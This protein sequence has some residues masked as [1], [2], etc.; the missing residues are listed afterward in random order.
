MDIIQLC[1]EIEIQPEIKEKVIQ[2]ANHFDFHTVDKYLKDFFVYEKMNEACIELCSIL[3]DDDQHIKILVCMLQASLYAYAIY[4]RKG[5][6]KD[7][8]I[9]TM[10]CYTRFIEE[11]YQ[12]TGKLDFDR[13][14]WTT[15]QAGCHLYRLGELEYEIKHIDSK[16]VI[17]IHIPSDACFFPSDVE[18]SINLAKHFFE[19]Y[20]PELSNC[21]YRCHSWL[22]DPKLKDMLNE[23]SNIISFQNQFEIYDKGEVSTEFIQ[24]LFNTKS[25]DHKSLP[26]NTTLQ[27]K[28]K[29]HILNGGVIYNAYGKLRG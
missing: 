14:W 29:E 1:D 24:W 25:Q 3:N 21:E 12:M 20:Y 18:K 2:F 7:I 23:K 19:N 10:K 26:E 16:I 15:R 17:G 22:L 27:R 4:Q 13:Y 8:Y 9:A 5:I 6:S 11:T 28:V